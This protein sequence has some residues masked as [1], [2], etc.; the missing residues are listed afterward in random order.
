LLK[1]CYLKPKGLAKKAAIVYAALI[2]Y[3]AQGLRA[4]ICD[5]NSLKT[6][7]K[8]QRLKPKIL[9]AKC[10][11]THAKLAKTGKSPDLPTIIHKIKPK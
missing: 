4:L 1:D 6:V 11:Q 10:L 2:I 3:T 5:E 9:V 7:N 8:Q